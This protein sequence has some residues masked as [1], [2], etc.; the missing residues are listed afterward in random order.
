ME[1]LI[2][3][4]EDEKAI[5]DILSFNLKREGYQIAEAEEGRNGYR[6]ATELRPDLIL[7][8]VMLPGMNGF[9]ICGRLREEGVLTPILMLTAKEEEPDKIRGLEIG[10]DDYITKP[11][12]MRELMARIKANIRR[13]AMIEPQQQEGGIC[14]GE[15]RVDPESAETFKN[16]QPLGLTQR[17]FELIHFLA[18][19]PDRVF[20]REELMDKVWNYGIYGDERTVD[21]TVRRLRNKVE[22]N[23][24]EP[25]Y[26]I[27]RRGLG[28][29]LASK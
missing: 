8:D 21:V 3:I 18:Q 22:D 7:L 15:L 17:E 19:T 6:M 10:A 27:T 26:I 11:F 5:R 9:E 23:P 2:L 13:S 16:G 12:S 29:L 25:R 4:V 1:R 28:Y 24:A 20:S 14:I